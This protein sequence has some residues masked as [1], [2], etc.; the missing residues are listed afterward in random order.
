MK[1]DWQV[2]PGDKRGGV[3]VTNE[4][5]AHAHKGTVYNLDSGLWTGLDSGP[6]S[7]LKFDIICT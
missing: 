1:L 3:A 5:F 7:G 6:K 2:V 4:T